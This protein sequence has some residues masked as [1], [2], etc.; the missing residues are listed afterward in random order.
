MSTDSFPGLE[1]LISALQH[2]G[3]DAAT[4]S[5]LLKDRL[6]VLAR[7]SPR[8][9]A[10]C[11]G[12]PELILPLL[13]DNVLDKSIDKE[14][15]RTQ[16]HESMQ[17]ADDPESA[18][19]KFHRQHIVR[20]AW[21][22]LCDLADIQQIT[23]ELSD[24]GDV[25]IDV[26]YKLILDQL[27][28]QY[29]QPRN[30]DDSET[31]QMVVVS[32]GKHGGRELNFSSDIDLMFV[33]DH[34]GMTTGATQPA[35]ENLTFFTQLAQGICDLLGKST[36]NGF[37]YRID[38]RLRPEGDS[39]AL[40]V[41]LF[42]VEHYYQTYGQN[43]ER[44]ALLKARP[45]A[46]D[47]VLGEK[48]SRIITPFTYRRYVDEIEIAEVLRG[49]D[50]MRER[51]LDN[52]GSS[53]QQANN[54]KNG[55]GGIRD[56]EFF[57]QAVQMLYGGQ[58]PEIKL[59]GTLVS[60]QRMY[61]SHL[62]HSKDFNTLST[63][64][65]FLRRIEHRMQMVADQQVYD[66]PTDSE[67]RERL[68]QSMG[69]D[70][71]QAL[72][73]Q[74]NKTSKDIRTIYNGVFQ[75]DEWQ[76]NFDFLI[77]DDKFSDEINDILMFYGFDDAKRAFSFIKHLNKSPDLHLQ[78]KTT[79]LFKSFLPRF[80]LCLK[81]CPDPDLALANF[82]QLISRFKARSALY[83]TLSDQPSFLKLLI[84]VI[85]CSSFLT[86]LIMRDPSLMETIGR[87][88]FLDEVVTTILLED[89]LQI[90]EKIYL[91]ES[92]RDHLLR[93]QNSAMFRSGI[94]FILGLDDVEQMGMNLA[95]IADFVL[96]ESLDPVREQMQKRYHDFSA[97]HGDE[98]AILGFGKLGGREFNVAS[99]CDVVYVYNKSSS[100]GGVASEEYFQRW[101]AKMTTYLEHNAPLGFLYH[102]DLR[103]R[104]HG[105]SGPQASSMETFAEYY[106]KQAQF[107]EKM[108]LS[109]ARYICGNP[110]IRLA[111]E[112]LKEEILFTSPP[113][114]EDIQSILDMRKKIEK[115]KGREKLKAGPGGL[116]DV[117]FIAQAILLC[118]GYAH[119]SIRL[120]STFGILRAASKEG[121][122]SDQDSAQLIKSYEFLRDVENRLRIVDNA[123]LDVLPDSPHELNKLTRRYTQ[124]LDIDDID[125]ESFL[126]SV[127]SHTHAVRE[128]YD[129]ILNELLDR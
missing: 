108:A 90:I 4:L 34:D 73:E 116:V 33:Y 40:A 51:S 26:V 14:T 102:P 70:S 22:D 52:I 41:S 30:E 109:R 122:L 56:I 89:H 62:L 80:L 71:W 42:K 111:L 93:V 76:D 117:E 128:I 75:R 96:D 18:L 65:R 9:A 3:C 57:V 55:Y 118:Y 115:E 97:E 2:N 24:L 92:H 77:D 103:L 36:A 39:G 48:F 1:N 74:Y 104:P 50:A 64:Y 110:E 8:L 10:I 81:E 45:V 99:D 107:W 63:A 20:I 37:L 86:R 95:Q 69:I 47:P 31:S 19:R 112:T 67:G 113:T 120:T 66:L 72:Y 46:G 60:L 124:H 68:A 58:Y 17:N 5:D 59:A 106:R 16:L 79:R 11:S 78:T 25:V 53:D 129:R 121:L 85:S 49:I 84:S 126:K 43:W 23:E 38:N 28:T 94:R 98:V 7:Y 12:K 21:R 82:E 101:A 13:P 35:V 119:P 127:D 100:L 87:D 114:K 32:M 105:A 27:I 83:E 125:S 88:G 61:E 29:G 123:S 54:F 91:K 44:Q 15:L 6:N